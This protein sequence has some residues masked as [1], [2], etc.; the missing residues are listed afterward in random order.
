MEIL[1]PKVS[2]RSRLNRLWTKVKPTWVGRHVTD[3]HQMDCALGMLSMFRNPKDIETLGRLMAKGLFERPLVGA[4]YWY[5]R[6]PLP[7]DPGATIPMVTSGANSVDFICMDYVTI[8]EIG[9]IWQVAG[10][11]TAV[12]IDF[13]KYTG[14]TGTGTVTDKLDGTNGVLTAPTVAGQ[15]IGNV[16][17]KD[18]GHTLNI[19]LDKGNSI[20]ANVTTTTT[21]GSGIPY[22]LVM[23]KDRL[24]ADVTT[25]IA[26]S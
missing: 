14:V 22:V 17:Y 5:G 25:L 26:S 24:N 23:P 6:Q 13:D 1:I 3:K 21:A 20:R 7:I 12:V 19:A 4:E 10:T 9:H 2:I 15:A 8:L 16:L 18:I 11:V